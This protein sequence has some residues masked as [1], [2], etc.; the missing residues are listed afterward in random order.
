M[1]FYGCAQ[2]TYEQ[3]ELDGVW[4]DIVA[5][6]RP[7]RPAPGTPAPRDLNLFVPLFPSR[8]SSSRRSAAAVASGT[9]PPPSAKRYLS[10]DVWRF[11]VL[12]FCDVST[13]LQLHA[14]CSQIRAMIEAVQFVVD[15]QTQAWYLERRCP[16]D[17]NLFYLKVGQFLEFAW[18]CLEIP[19]SR[20]SDVALRACGRCVNMEL[21]PRIPVPYLDPRNSPRCFLPGLL[22]IWYEHWIVPVPRMTFVRV[23]DC[24]VRAP[25]TTNSPFWLDHH[26]VPETDPEEGDTPEQRAQIGVVPPT[27]FQVLGPDL[28]TA[29]EQDCATVHRDPHDPAQDNA[30]CLGYQAVRWAR[31]RMYETAVGVQTYPLHLCLRRSDLTGRAYR[32]GMAYLE[33]QFAPVNRPPT[34]HAGFPANGLGILPHNGALY[35]HPVRYNNEA[36][37][38]VPWALSMLALQQGIYRHAWFDGCH[39]VLSRMDEFVRELAN[40]VQ[41]DLPMYAMAERWHHLHRRAFLGETAQVST[42]ALDDIATETIPHAERRARQ[43]QWALDL[44]YN[45]HYATY[46]RVIGRYAE[47]EHLYW[48]SQL[49]SPYPGHFPYLT[50]LLGDAVRAFAGHRTE[51]MLVAELREMIRVSDYIVRFA[52]TVGP[53]TD[54]VTEL[55]RYRCLNAYLGA[56]TSLIMFA[57]SFR[58]VPSWR[59]TAS[60]AS[61]PRMLSHEIPT[62]NLQHNH[63]YRRYLRWLNRRTLFYVPDPTYPP[64]SYRS[65]VNPRS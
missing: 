54:P 22:D 29:Y 63:R 47:R 59:R 64:E 23:E 12:Y 61:G 15:W 3:L 36:G 39:H 52:L 56:A 53:L 31:R 33:T 9:C 38:F 18:D 46:N 48:D 32:S 50:E 21:A 27:H 8:R 7:Q 14:T 28:V 34:P 19:N 35:F 62:V 49:G 65:E 45:P 58:R 2:P 25:L 30:E 11:H 16:C 40:E 17:R 5:E 43:D 20:A 57:P 55:R 1:D 26:P 44:M 60:A 37:D 51:A 10:P 24:N 4:N 6:E 42:T 13:L 41:A